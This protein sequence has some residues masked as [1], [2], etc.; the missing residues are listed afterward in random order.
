MERKETYATQQALPGTNAMDTVVI[1]NLR[2]QNRFLYTKYPETRNDIR[3]LHF[4]HWVEFGGLEQACRVTVQCPVCR[5]N[6]THSVLDK[7]KR[8]WTSGRPRTP[9]TVARRGREVQN[10]QGQYKPSVAVQRDRAKKAK[11]GPVLR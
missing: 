2:D 8:W 3:L 5:H 10:D 7:I 6:A 4:Y 9:S 1:T 11:Q